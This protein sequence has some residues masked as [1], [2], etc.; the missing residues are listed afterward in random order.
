MKNLF[1]EK[2]PPIF[3]RDLFLRTFEAARHTNQ[4]FAADGGAALQMFAVFL[5]VEV[6]FQTV[7]AFGGQRTDRAALHAEQ[8]AAVSSWWRQ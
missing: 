6:A 3:R 2:I 8:T 5:Q 1:H 4:A 7:E